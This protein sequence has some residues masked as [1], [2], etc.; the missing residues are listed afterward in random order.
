MVFVPLLAQERVNGFVSLQ[1]VDREHAFSDSDV[2]L[3][4][5]LTASMS[6][7]LENAR[8]FDET[9]RLLKETEERNAELAA[10]SAVSQA[11]VAETELDS[12][13]QLIGDQ[14][15]EIFGA[16]IVYLALLDPQTN[17]IHF[18]YQVGESFTTLNY[19]EGLTSK[20]I[21]SGEPLLLNRDVAESH[22]RLGASRV[23]TEA[24]SY[25]GVPIK[26]G[27]ET[28][29]VLSVQSTQQEE[30][31]D[32]GS[33]R[34]LTTIAA[35]AGAAIQTARLHAE[36]QRR[37]REMA[38]L[39]QVGRE[40]SASLDLSTVLERITTHAQDLL[41]AD[42]S[43]VFLPDAGRP[44]TF[45]AIA[46]IGDI[47][48]QLKTT[49]IVS[50]TGIIGDVA[51]KG[52][53]EVVNNT[54]NDPRGIRIAGTERQ[55]HE[56]L[57][58]APLLAPEGLR[59]LMSVWRIG[60]GREF[61]QDDLNFLKGLSQQAV[62][63]LENARLYTEAQEA[64]RMA[65][66]ANQAKSAFLATMSHE[67]RTPLN[68]I[69]GFTRIVQRKAGGVLPDKQL[70]NL[71][72]VLTSAEHLLSLINSILDI[73]KIEAGH[74]DVAVTEVE[75]A[76]LLEECATTTRP[77]IRRGVTLATDIPPD[78]P[79]AFS[80]QD[81]IKQIVLNLLSN[82]AKFTHD[83]S[84][85]VRARAADGEAGTRLIIE[86]SD[87]GIGIEKEQ[88]EHIFEEFQQADSSTTREYGGTGLGLSISKH[89]AQL[90]GG[91]LTAASTPGEGSTFAL[92]LPLTYGQ[93][94]RPRARAESAS[95]TET[96][97]ADDFPVR[98][99]GVPAD[100]SPPLIL[101]IDDNE[102]VV[103]ILQEN[104]GD[105]G[106]QVVGAATAADGL[107]RARELR[108]AAITLDII[109]P[110]R[111]GW[112]VLHELKQDPVTWDI[113][114]IVLSVVERRALGF[115]LGATDYLVKPFDS[116]ALIS[117][118]QRV[119]K[120]GS[121]VRRLLVVDDDPD[122]QQMVTQ[123]LEEEPVEIM[124]VTDGLE[125]L[126]HIG[127]HRPDA[128][129]LDLM[130]PRLDGFGV[131]ARMRQD[132]DLA[133]IPVVVLTAKQ[134]SVEESSRLQDTVRQILQ[135]DGLTGERLFAALQSVFTKEGAADGQNIDR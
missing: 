1:N 47:A 52:V 34:L 36:T 76:R 53:A 75:V 80:D 115:Q 113:P 68:A 67:L 118:L 73:A 117:T 6:V 21:E 78:L 26:A 71:G 123:L 109:L 15:R 10:I 114:V 51:Q 110:D 12:L 124:A 133:D 59:G 27:R 82:A 112:Q 63:A 87:S 93:P 39:A 100:A 38:T 46:A 96:R 48:A 74:V 106:Y 125:A 4:E 49:E 132:P 129:L 102:H 85:N 37:A 24:L 101:A 65:E 130:M 19:G 64:K 30:S 2:R 81:K 14:L 69:I 120:S 89:L 108:P 54:E 107:A 116:E 122:V 91:D 41:D 9:E 29:G 17:V 28:I 22:E 58:A 98:D 92:W 86:V 40:I 18:P 83:G 95:E 131:L 31:F 61:D 33:L 135:K 94:D 97:R 111:D 70:D 11:L 104:L 66:Q 127:R 88:L 42:S 77:L 121:P 79:R 128:I 20:I 56:H 16:D 62:I 55:V 90:L 25:L 119:T 99:A 50:G 43:A 126:A 45:T 13:I 105:A 7:A 44:N 32:D 57:M 103:E 23:G 5:T 134:L 60:E 8:L 35:N 84:V 72:K 3:L